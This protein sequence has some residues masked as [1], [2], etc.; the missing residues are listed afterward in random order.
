MEIALDGWDIGRAAQI[1]KVPWGSR[2]DARARILGG[3]DGFVLVL[4]EA[5]AGYQ[6]D[7]HEH[8]HPELLYVVDGAVRTQGVELVRGDGYAASAGST[9]ADFASP[10]GAVYLSIFKL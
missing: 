7:A 4:V 2:G 8:T 3:A 5:D 10:S 6:G 1:E 9:H